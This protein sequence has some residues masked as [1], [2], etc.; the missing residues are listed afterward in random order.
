MITEVNIG[1]DIPNL[2]R[3][4]NIIIKILNIKAEV[5]IMPMRLKL[6][7]NAYV[8]AYGNRYTV[9]LNS[10]ILKNDKISNFNIRLL[11]HELTHVQQME[12]GDLI[13]KEGF[14]KAI[15]KGREYV[16]SDDYD[17]RPFEIEA[18]KNEKLYFNNVKELLSL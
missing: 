13:F 7:G 15:W 14:K 10:D 6:D 1:Y 12:R 8:T 4:S 16:S 5:Y 17:S 2:V 3:L 18:R 11:I 9:Y